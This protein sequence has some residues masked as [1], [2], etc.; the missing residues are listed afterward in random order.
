MEKLVKSLLN[1]QPTALILG[2]SIFNDESTQSN[3]VS[4]F[5]NF[6]N[7]YKMY[8]RLCTVVILLNGGLI[9]NWLNNIGIN[10][11]LCLY[12]ISI[13]PDFF[14]NTLKMLQGLNPNFIV[15]SQSHYSNFP[16]VEYKEV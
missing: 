1:K 7:R 16:S 3:V 2:P 4:S 13:M 8:L 6:K 12:S 10:I 14:S 5:N 9:G 15:L 11:I